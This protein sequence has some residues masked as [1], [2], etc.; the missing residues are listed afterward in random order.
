MAKR[1]GA[2]ND[3]QNITQKTKDLATRTSQ[4]QSHVIIFKTNVFIFILCIQSMIFCNLLVEFYH[5]HKQHAY[6]SQ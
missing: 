1:K 5:D 2:N 4:L 3:L 6:K